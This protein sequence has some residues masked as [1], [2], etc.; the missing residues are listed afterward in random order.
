METMRTAYAEKRDSVSTR[1][2]QNMTQTITNTREYVRGK[3]AS[4]AKN[5]LFRW[6]VWWT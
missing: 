4:F 5:I 2:K 6:I 3:R 1:L